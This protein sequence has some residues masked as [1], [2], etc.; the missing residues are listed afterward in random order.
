[1]ARA[2][3]LCP[4]GWEPL[5]R[6]ATYTLRRASTPSLSKARRIR[7][8]LHYTERTAKMDHP[9]M[10][11]DLPLLGIFAGLTLALATM[12]PAIWTAWFLALVTLCLRFTANVLRML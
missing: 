7:P 2:P 8:R 4:S 5:P 1:M 6:S 9:G 11:T 12:H 10:K 3:A